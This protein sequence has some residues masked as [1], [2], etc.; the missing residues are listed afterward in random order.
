[1]KGAARADRIPDRLSTVAVVDHHGDSER[2]Q[3]PRQQARLHKF[4]RR[5]S[6]HRSPAQ[7]AVRQHFVPTDREVLGRPVSS[8]VSSRPQPA[9]I[10][11]SSLRKD[12]RVAQASSSR[13][14]SGRPAPGRAPR[15]ISTSHSAQ[16]VSAA[17]RSLERTER[18]TPL[19]RQL[20][21]R[22]E[23][24]SNPGGNP[25]RANGPRHGTA[26][27]CQAA[28]AGPTRAAHRTGTFRF[29]KGGRARGRGDSRGL[30][31]VDPG[32]DRRTR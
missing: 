5:S 16:R 7:S 10:S 32:C 22:V 9:P 3:K 31:R 20:A 2:D 19:G 8:D 17:A 29:M 1:V 28:S 21:Q 4:G 23:S 26:A 11:Q 6:K 18:G 12:A 14:T 25:T 15:Q 30:L 27:R 13:P 24:R